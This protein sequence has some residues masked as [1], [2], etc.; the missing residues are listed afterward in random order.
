MVAEGR[1]SYC[2]IHDLALIEYV[3]GKV[4]G[5]VDSVYEMQDALKAYE[6]I[7]SWRATGKVVVKIDDRL[8]AHDS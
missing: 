6:R 8:Q 3:L 2:D 5:V 1:E 4:V 7:L